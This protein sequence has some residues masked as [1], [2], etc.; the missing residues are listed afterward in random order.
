M[1]KLNLKPLSGFR[2]ILPQDQIAFDKIRQTIENTYK[3]T[4]FLKIETPLIERMEIL[5]GK[6]GEENQ[7]LMYE[8]KKDKPQGLRFDLTVPFSRYFACNFNDLPLPFKRF[9]TEKVYRGE[10]AQAGRLREFYQS[11]IDIL[12]REI[13]GMN[14]FEIISCLEIALSKIFDN[15]T[16]DSPQIL[17][18]SV[19]KLGF[20]IEIGHRELWNIFFKENELSEKSVE[21]L[22]TVDAYKKVDSQ[23]F[24]AM[25]KDINL[26]DSIIEKINSIIF[27]KNTDEL[28]KLLQNSES[29]KYIDDLNLILNNVKNTKLN[30]GI[31]RGLD[32]YTGFVFETFF[33]DEKLKKYGSISSGG[34]YDNLVDAFLP[35][36]GIKGIGGSIGLSRLFDILKEEN[37]LKTQP[38]YDFIFVNETK[39]DF[40]EISKLSKLINKT[41]LNFNNYK[42]SVKFASKF[43]IPFIIIQEQTPEGELQYKVKTVNGKEQETFKK[44]ELNQIKDFIEKYGDK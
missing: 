1:S 15:N 13:T 32:Y 31:T 8:I 3:E 42:K 2:D 41:F 35:K 16:N 14:C 5:N 11:D 28:K 43:S 38:L 25:L 23:K 33:T 10:R 24:K 18:S 34:Q 6:G 39:S 26:S 29:E 40:L 21:I 30:M 22:T 9:Q 20:Q 36:S 37:L 44:T 17:K 19:G 7:K 12:N 27:C 4:G